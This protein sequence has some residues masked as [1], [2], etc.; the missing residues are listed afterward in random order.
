METQNVVVEMSNDYKI[1]RFAG[2]VWN[3][4]ATDFKM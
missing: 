2:V 4:R 3:Q 1:L